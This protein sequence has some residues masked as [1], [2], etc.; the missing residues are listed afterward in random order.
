MTV[1][2]MTGFGRAR[3][4]LATEWS[5]E[6]SARSV[7]HRFLDLTV[8]LRD[9]EAA[10]EPVLR[11]VFTRHLARGKVDLTLRLTRVGSGGPKIVIDERL[12]ESL[13]SRLDDLSQRYPIKGDLEARDLI[14]IP[15]L[16]SLDR[17]SDG[18]TPE[19]VAGLERLAEEVA[20]ALVGM[21]EEEGRRIAGELSKRI[22]F[23]ESKLAPL[24]ARRD[25]IV[26]SIATT[27]RDR[28]RALFSD[29]PLDAGRL[30]QEAALFAERSDV[31][32]ELARLAGHLAQFR[33]L[34]EKGDGPVGKKLDFLSQ[35]ILRE[36]NTLGSK[37]RDLQLAREV[38]DMK[39]ETEKIRE[40]VQNLE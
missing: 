34:L 33:S 19:E 7:N 1:R 26:R 32:E 17:P 40:Q 18:F 30:E 21:R 38:L 27:L 35:E 12:L 8:R 11:Q 29:V 13:L 3:G 2:S 10:L 31:A 37:A 23:L 39:A 25:E 36:I 6:L 20:T 9:S 24:N 5:A 14:A 28:M 16:L 4:P 15:E 22:V